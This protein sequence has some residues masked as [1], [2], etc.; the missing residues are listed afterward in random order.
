MI[1]ICVYLFSFFRG[2]KQG[3]HIF[4]HFVGAVP[5]STDLEQC[6]KRLL[7]ELNAVTVSS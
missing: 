6:I 7:K 3:W 4:Y 5:G 2:G 1:Q